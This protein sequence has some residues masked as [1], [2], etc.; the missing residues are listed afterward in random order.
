MKASYKKRYKSLLNSLG[1]GIVVHDKNAKVI[2]YNKKAKEILELDEQLIRDSQTFPES[3]CFLSEDGEQLH[4]DSYPVHQILQNGDPI[5]EQVV[6]IS[7]N[8]DQSTSWFKVSGL[9]ITD[10]MGAI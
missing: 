4:V 10:E 8:D 3:W 6:G 1:A 2:D 5:S 9:P 7:Q